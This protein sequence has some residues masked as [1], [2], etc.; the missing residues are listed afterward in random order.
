L[1]E[2]RTHRYDT[3]SKYKTCSETVRVSF[4]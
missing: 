4:L 1:F 3:R 2:R